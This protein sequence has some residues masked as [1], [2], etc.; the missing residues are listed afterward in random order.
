MTIR[1]S[2]LTMGGDDHDL[3]SGIAGNWW[4][5][6]ST[7]V[8][9]R[10]PRMGRHSPRSPRRCSRSERSRAP[11]ML[12]APQASCTDRRSETL[13]AHARLMRRR[14]CACAVSIE[15][16]GS[17]VSGRSSSVRLLILPSADW[18]SVAWPSVEGKSTSGLCDTAEL[19]R[20]AEVDAALTLDGPENALRYQD[21]C[22]RR[23]FAR[24]LR[25]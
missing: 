12:G 22:S 1:L 21:G 10:R 14:H 18:N 2:L 15:N 5:S 4:R 16:R 3:E 7:A 19:R 8:S 24:P 17:F 11:I 20:H 6:A 23:L 25:S 9:A 13:L